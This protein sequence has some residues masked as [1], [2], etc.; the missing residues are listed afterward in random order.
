[1]NKLS[2]FLRK[3]IYIAL[4]GVLSIPLALVSRPETRDE[5]GNIKDGGGKISRLRDDY[6]LS[7]AKMSEIDPASETMK[8]ASLGLR[9]VAV[10]ALWLQAMEYKKKEEYEQLAVTLKSLTKIQPN[11]VK[12]WE[13][14]AHN[15]AYNVSMEFDDYE[16]RYHWVKEGIAFLKEGVAYNKTDHRITDDMGF[17]TGNKLGKSDE[18]DSFRRM[19]RK[20]DEFHQ[21]ISDYIEPATYHTRD[22]EYGYDSWKM[23]YQWYDYSRKLV[24]QGAPKRA[25]D[26]LFYMY[27]P[28]QLRNQGMSM[29]KEFRT[30]EKIQNIWRDARDQW[31]VYGEEPISNTL[32]VTYN[33]E[34]MVKYEREL[35]SY[36]QQLDEIVP[37]VR[38]ELTDELLVLANVPEEDVVAWKMPPDQRS[39]LQIQQ[40]RQVNNVIQSLDNNL[41]GRIAEQAQPEDQLKARRLV[42]EIQRLLRQISTIDRDS[43]TI[44]YKYWRA[45][46]TAESTDLAVGARQALF[47]AEEMRRKSIYDDEYDRDLQTGETTVT[48]KGAISLYLEAFEKWRE[49]LEEHPDLKI[50]TTADDLAESMSE[51]R[52]M[53]YITNREWPKN[54]P[55]QDLIDARAAAGEPDKLPTSESLESQE[56]LDDASSSAMNEEE[57]DD[58]PDTTQNESPEDESP[59]KKTDDPDNDNS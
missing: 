43:Q 55:L 6:Q 3:I 2:P 23:A 34:G 21:Q 1:M 19:F 51:F 49:V 26:L 10:S 5:Y 14:Q 28:A 44:N 56:E 48:K 41:D 45:R 16:Y 59:D 40:A 8:L 15:L 50:G 7:Q 33:L 57:S 13:F 37:G 36:R 58:K 11:F 42:D 9:G 46:T 17:F 29:Q 4:I 54:F 31:R 47:D 25:S 53:L 27:R 52:D 32:G 35:D 12:V 18:K 24:E 39:D 30:D 22:K 38:Q 20:D